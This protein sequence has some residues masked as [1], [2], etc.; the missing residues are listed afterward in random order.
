[1]SRRL[2][3]ACARGLLALWAA[4]FPVA[5][6]AQTSSELTGRVLDTDGDGLVGA[7]VLIEETGQSVLSG[8]GG[9]YTI[10]GIAPGNY[11]VLAIFTGLVR[12]RQE[13]VVTAQGARLDFALQE[14]LLLLEETVLVSKAANPYSVLE[15]SVAAT[16]LDARDVRERGPRSTADIF[17]SIPGLWVEDAVGQ[18]INDVF[19]RG[20]PVGGQTRFLSIME[21][22]VPLIPSG[23]IA[24]LFADQFLRIDETLER[25]ESIRGGSSA[26]L[27]SNAPGGIVNFVSRTGGPRLGGVLKVSTADHGLA[28]LDASLGGP[29]GDDWRFHVGG[30]VR[31]DRGVIDPGFTANA[32]GQ[33]KGN[34]TRTFDRG[35]VRFHL[36]VLDERN[37]LDNGGPYLYDD[38]KLRSLPGFELGKDTYTSPD[39]ID[40]TFPLPGGGTTTR[41]IRDGSSARQIAFG[42]DADF[43]LGS[44]WIL[45]N[46]FRYADSRA[47]AD[48]DLTL[49]PPIPM[50]A[51]GFGFLSILGPAVGAT[52]FEFTR[53]AD[54]SSVDPF[55]NNGNGLVGLTLPVFSVGSV[56]AVTNRTEVRRDFGNHQFL[57]GVSFTRIDMSRVIRSSFVAKEVA[58]E[59]GLI[60]L[61]LTGSPFGPL[62][63][64]LGGFY[65]FGAS[66]ENDIVTG[67]LYGLYANDTFAVGNRLRVDVGV[68]YEHHDLSNLVELTEVIDLD[69]NPFTLY[70]STY[71]NGTGEFRDIDLGLDDWGASVGLNYLLDDRT[72]LFARASRGFNALLVDKEPGSE[73]FHIRQVEA[74]VKH[75]APRLG[76]MATLFYTDVDDVPFID[77]RR[78]PDG[79]VTLFTNFGSSRTYGLELEVEANV[80]PRLNVRATATLQDPEYTDFRFLDPN[81]GT[82]LDFTGNVPSR[83]PRVLLDLTSTYDFGSRTRAHVSLRHYGRRYS[84]DRNTID[85]SAYSELH[86]G[87]T[88]LFGRWEIAVV[89]SNL[90]N[91]R[92][93]TT[94][95]ASF[96]EAVAPGVLFSGFPLLGRASLPR[97]LRLS[98]AYRF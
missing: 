71:V 1:M 96:D 81:T 26:V 30:F 90:T 86:A 12:E 29:L 16:I 32:G 84:N 68:R 38:G 77:I 69:G 50:A 72:A 28:R 52:G 7:V 21:D 64:S 47:D 33:F 91:T 13:V 5:A 97:S 53:A 41:S 51:L 40:Y 66:Y 79:T 94:G 6:A 4:C 8:R 67:N 61:T 9:A 14:Y 60:D 74:G 46:S 76:L 39:L 48:F 24:F 78:R 65:T 56:E 83:Q 95:N 85:L 44:G 89:G 19:V 42:F 88:W 57:A 55:T 43:D 87:A 73:N 11:H 59:P 10:A 82:T 37:A 27:A 25:V 34:L 18:A 70:D 31:R 93:L 2:L 54:G 20:I 92:A 63:V 22:G 62:P 23:E 3:Y 45:S 98:T 58:D 15:S 17:R 75:S 80:A 49:D 35:L 36:K